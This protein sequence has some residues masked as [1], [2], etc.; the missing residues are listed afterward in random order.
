MAAAAATVIITLFPL[1]KN[2]DRQIGLSM[3]V[4]I[5]LSVLS[6]E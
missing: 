5:L 3:R 1:R 4:S 6:V 2:A